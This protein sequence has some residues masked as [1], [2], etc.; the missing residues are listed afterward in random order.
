MVD[1]SFIN[2]EEK[3]YFSFIIPL[4]RIFCL[5]F[6]RVQ[7]KNLKH[8]KICY[9]EK[10]KNYHPNTLKLAKNILIVTTPTSGSYVR[11]GMK[12][13]PYLQHNFLVCIVC[14]VLHDS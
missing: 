1:A 10:L 14:V 6:D 11:E 8:I 13:S 3:Y 2:P 5:F 9:L 12:M 7:S 4:Y